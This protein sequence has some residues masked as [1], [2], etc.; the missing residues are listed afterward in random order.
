MDHCNPSSLPS[1][2]LISPDNHYPTPSLQ[3]YSFPWLQIYIIL[4]DFELYMEGGIHYGFFSVGLF[5]PHFVRHIYVAVCLSLVSH[6]V[7]SNSLQP[8]ELQHAMMDRLLCPSPSPGACPNSCPLSQWCH[9]TI[10]SSVT[11]SPP[12]LSLSQHQGLFQRV[13]SSHQ[14]VKVL[15][16]QHQ[17]FQGTFRADFL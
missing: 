12:A 15:E 5:A 7:V 6:S 14:V 11:P 4:A 10:M 2:F 1:S 17:S 16:L 9:P 8:H 13:G 3:A